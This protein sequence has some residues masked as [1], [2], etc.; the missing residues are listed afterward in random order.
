MKRDSINHKCQELSHLVWFVFS[1]GVFLWDFLTLLLQMSGNEESTKQMIVYPILKSHLIG[2]AGNPQTSHEERS[3][4]STCYYFLIEEQTER[5]FLS[6]SLGQSHHEK[7]IP[8]INGR[9]FGRWY[10]VWTIWSI[11]FLV[12]SWHRTLYEYKRKLLLC[13]ILTGT[14]TS[15]WMLSSPT[16]WW[17]C[18]YKTV[19]SKYDWHI[20]VISLL[21]CSSVQG[22]LPFKPQDNRTPS[23]KLSFLVQKPAHI[24]KPC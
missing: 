1:F 14:Y 19:R 22:S 17:K 4:K 7:V 12:L 3:N 23:G 15:R 16:F 10:G 13:K 5:S 9:Y 6:H 21:A 2:I 18:Q 8:Q 20:C 11:S 24:Y